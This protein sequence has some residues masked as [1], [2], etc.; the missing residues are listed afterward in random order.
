[1]IDTPGKSLRRVTWRFPHSVK[2]GTSI[3]PLKTSGVNIVWWIDHLGSGGS[4]QILVRLIE[5]MSKKSARQRVICFNQ[6]T[7]R[8]LTDRIRAA[9]CEIHILRP[10]TLLT[11]VGFFSAFKIVLE[12]KFDV[13]VT[14]LFAADIVGTFVAWVGQIPTRISG[15][16][17]SN[18]HYSFLHRKL[19][20]LALR[21]A[22][23]IVLNSGAYQLSAEKFL[24]SN[25]PIDEIPNGIVSTKFIQVN[26]RDH[27]H[28]EL[29]LAQ[30][31]YLVG[32][33]G[34]L[35]V[36]K[37]LEDVLRAFA[38]IEDQK[39][40]LVLAGDGPQRRHLLLLRNSLNLLD[41]VHFLGVRYDIPEV[42]SSLALYVQA[43]AFE[44]MSNSLME[45][46]ASG[47][48]VIVSA[49]PG[50]LELVS[51][52]ETGWV[53]QVGE[54]PKLAKLI[55]EVMSQPNLAVRYAVAAQKKILYNYS[56]DRMLNSWAKRVLQ[57]AERC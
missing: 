14:F 40:H 35:A 9:G 36:E 41:R 47:C 55:T 32:C 50:N 12:N 49:I 17:S 53:F 2:K 3:K 34:R 52:R 7:N 30:D 25:V 20:K 5:H 33:V 6:S 45:A 11:G 22:T 57:V 54:A 51:D 26:Q 23:L 15:Q 21:K 29:N 31:V 18:C 27:L 43:S 42:L 13:S 38:L 44:G 10:I 39:I 16:R 4:Q 8:A 1:V 28:L 48:P 19:M 37:G 24:P 56:E 46:M